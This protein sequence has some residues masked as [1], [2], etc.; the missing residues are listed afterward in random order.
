M[1][2]PVLTALAPVVRVAG[3]DT[4]IP[5]SLV[6]EKHILPGKEQVVAGVKRVMA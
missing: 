2:H 5:F 3:L 4:P 6:L 1:N